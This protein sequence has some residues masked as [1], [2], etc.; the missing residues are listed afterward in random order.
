MSL[1]DDFKKGLC[2]LELVVEAPACIHHLAPNEDINVVKHLFQWQF[3]VNVQVC[4][5][6]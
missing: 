4:K 3:A 5:A 2:Q 1:F 6:H